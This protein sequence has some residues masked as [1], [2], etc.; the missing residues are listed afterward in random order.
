MSFDLSYAKHLSSCC[1]SL[2][3]KCCILHLSPVFFQ[4]YKC[5]LILFRC[6]HWS[7]DNGTTSAPSKIT[8]IQMNRRVCSNTVACADPLSTDALKQCCGANALSTK[9]TSAIEVNLPWSWR[10]AQGQTVL[11]IL[12]TYLMCDL[13][14]VMVGIFPLPH[15]FF[16]CTCSCLSYHMILRQSVNKK[17]GKKAREKK[18]EIRSSPTSSSFQSFPSLCTDTGRSN[19]ARS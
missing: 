3:S 19:V 13:V 8:V 6:S 7:A 18:A 17:G 14:P 16:L 2:L 10:K 5:F 12:Y 4:F 11:S 9:N 15:L 1:R